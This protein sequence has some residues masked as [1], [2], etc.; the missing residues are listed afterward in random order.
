[1]IPSGYVTRRGTAG[2]Y[3]NPR[4]CFFEGPPDCFPQ[5]LH[6]F[7]FPPAANQFRFLL[8]LPILVTFWWCFCFVGLC[9]LGRALPM[10]A[11]CCQLS[12]MLGREM[13]RHPFCHVPGPQV[14]LRASSDSTRGWI[15]VQAWEKCHSYVWN[16]STASDM[17]FAVGYLRDV[18]SIPRSL[19]YHE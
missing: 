16:P 1:M 7:T 6:R 10:G 15:R 5:Q 14:S 8:S 18:P 17:T 19:S 13:A 3:R 2:S 11:R 12:A 9:F 4:C